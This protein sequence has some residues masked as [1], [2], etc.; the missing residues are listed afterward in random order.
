[1]KFCIKSAQRFRYYR[2][3]IDP[4]TFIDTHFSCRQTGLVYFNV[5]R[6]G[7]SLNYVD[8]KILKFCK[9]DV[10]IE[11]IVVVDKMKVFKISIR[12]LPFKTD[13]WQEVLL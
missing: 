3:T 11:K 4:L 7:K 9:F 13:Y 12:S 10:K 6:V 8:V 2:G 1:M 5:L